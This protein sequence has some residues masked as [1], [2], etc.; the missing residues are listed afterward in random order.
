MHVI[1]NGGAD[2]CQW[3]QLS[4]GVYP[5]EDRDVWRYL[6]EKQV[7]D[8]NEAEARTSLFFKNVFSQVT[9]EVQQVFAGKRPLSPGD[10]A[11]EWRNHLST[12]GNRSRLYRRVITECDKV[13]RVHVHSFWFHY[14]H[15]HPARMSSIVE[16]Q[17]GTSCRAV[18]YC[19][20][21]PWPDSAPPQNP[22]TSKSCCISM[23]H[24]NLANPLWWWGVVR[25]AMMSCG[26]FC[27]TS[28][29]PLSL[30]CSSPPNHL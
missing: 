14:N 20:L 28:T 23:K 9:S 8:E 19:C 10:L 17:R 18:L 27:S 1:M 30:Q 26:R 21:Q 7:K 22:R 5:P 4:V 25:H 13:G 15:G 2:H 6:C 12:E 11:L 29:P 24:M 3:S 16:V